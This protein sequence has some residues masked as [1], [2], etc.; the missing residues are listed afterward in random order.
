MKNDAGRVCALIVGIRAK[1][2]GPL[3]IK[4]IYQTLSGKEPRT[5]D[6][7]DP[8]LIESHRRAAAARANQN[9]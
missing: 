8:I 2:L 4:R 7:N 3:G 9:K 5:V 6:P 1:K